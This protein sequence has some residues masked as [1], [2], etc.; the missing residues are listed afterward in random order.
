MNSAIFEKIA[1]HKMCDSFSLQHLSG[2]FLILRRNEPDMIINVY[3]STR[4]NP[5][6]LSDVNGSL[7]FSTDFRKV[8]KYRI[9]WKSAH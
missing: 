5:L 4:K 2:I 8:L 1:E 3:W 6:F 7:I 9:S